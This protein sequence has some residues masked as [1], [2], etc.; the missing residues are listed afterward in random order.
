MRKDTTNLIIWFDE[1]FIPLVMLITRRPDLLLHYNDPG[2]SKDFNRKNIEIKISHRI[3]L[4]R[5]NLRICGFF[6]TWRKDK[7]I[8]QLFSWLTTHYTGIKTRGGEAAKSICFR[9]YLR[10]SCNTFRCGY[11]YLTILVG[12]NSSEIK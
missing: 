10:F 11:F 4:S 12:N 1:I 9:S 3:L 6:H 5:N 8:Y 7:N 2:N